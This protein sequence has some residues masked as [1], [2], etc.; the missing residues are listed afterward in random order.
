MLQ[1]THLKDFEAAGLE[2]QQSKQP[3]A[4]KPTQQ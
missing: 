2:K 1:R 3:A 4:K